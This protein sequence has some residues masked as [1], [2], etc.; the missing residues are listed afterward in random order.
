MP[1]IYCSKMLA[2][3]ITHAGGVKMEEF[4]GQPCPWWIVD[5]CGG[6][7]IRDTIGGGILSSS[8]RFSEF[9][10]GSKPVY[11]WVLTA[12]KTSTP[13][14][15][16]WKTKQNKTKKQTKKNVSWCLKS[17][18]FYAQWSLFAQST[19]EKPSI[20]THLGEGNL[21]FGSEIF[22]FYWLIDYWLTDWLSSVCV[23]QCSPFAH[24]SNLSFWG[25]ILRVKLG[26]VITSWSIIFNVILNY[27][28]LW[29]VSSR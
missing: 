21:G 24:N 26:I 2:K 27:L 25:R 14:L 20:S 7:F 16:N 23:A 9:S 6:A 18:L 8:Q 28:F 10:S 22:R 29:E 15:G 11:E 12:L 3:A 5:N 19:L 17:L 1:H 4:M 13:R